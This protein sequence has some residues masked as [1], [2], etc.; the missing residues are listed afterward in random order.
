LGSGSSGPLDDPDGDTLPNLLEY[1]FGNSNPT[2]ASSVQPTLPHFISGADGTNQFS[3]SYLRRIGGYWLNGN[4][5]V[6][7]LAYIP[8]A[9]FDLANWNLGLMEVANPPNLPA[10]PTSFEWITYKI[11]SLTNQPTGF[12]AVKVVL[13][14]GL[15]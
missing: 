13:P 12:G 11:S 3:F 15:P 7:D 2:N 8:Q 6:G 1:A 5:H 9:S 4:Y 14:S 10:A